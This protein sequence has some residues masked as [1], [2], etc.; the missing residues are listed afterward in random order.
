MGRSG[1]NHNKNSKKKRRSKKNQDRSH[2]N[3]S[4]G[5]EAYNSV[6]N[7]MSNMRSDEEQVQVNKKGKRKPMSTRYAVPKDWNIEDANKAF[8]AENEINNFVKRRAPTLILKFPDPELNQTVI[9][10]FSS[11]ISFVHFQ[12]PCTPR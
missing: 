12:Q 3:S 9:K 2:D 7:N 6:A 4:F 8:Q 5:S 1:R 11:H 10:A